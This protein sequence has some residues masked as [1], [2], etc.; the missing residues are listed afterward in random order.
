MGAAGQEDF[1]KNKQGKKLLILIA[2]F[3]L[4]MAAAVAAYNGLTKK[5]LGG[6][7]VSPPASQTGETSDASSSALVNKEDFPLAPDFS[8]ED[9]DGNTVKLSD[10]RGTPVVLNFW[11]SWCGPCRAE[12]PHFQTL[13]DE[14][15]D[16]VIFLMVNL[17]D[18]SRETKETAQAFLAGE[19][20]NFTHLVF[21]TNSE[22]AYNYRVSS[23][24]AEG[25]A[26]SR[27]IGALSE[28][29]LRSRVETILP[30]EE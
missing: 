3:V 28:Q 6:Q 20:F 5:Y 15:K 13:M 16:Q 11:A 2:A 1:M 29:T 23:I 4:V 17:T 30:A 9:A 21:D 18:G 25:Y 8:V 19:S 14:H 27:E 26:L 10:Y 7:A 12:M 24:D 22:A